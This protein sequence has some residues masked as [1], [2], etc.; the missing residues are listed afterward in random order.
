MNS[1]KSW[2]YPVFILVTFTIIESALLVGVAKHYELGSSAGVV[3]Y[4]IAIVTALA[5]LVF[6]FRK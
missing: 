5:G 3:L 6:A 4:F 1:L 2:A